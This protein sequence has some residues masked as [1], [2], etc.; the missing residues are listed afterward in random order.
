VI[1]FAM[2]ELKKGMV[3]NLQ[4]LVC[5]EKVLKSAGKQRSAELLHHRKN[6]GGHCDEAAGEA[7]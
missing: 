7:S 4:R 1:A 5:R 2:S 3:E 6:W